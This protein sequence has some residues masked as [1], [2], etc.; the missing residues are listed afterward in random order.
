MAPPRSPG[1]SLEEGEEE[2][3]RKI[4]EEGQGIIEVKLEGETSERTL[5]AA[6][7]DAQ[8]SASPQHFKEDS[9]KKCEGKISL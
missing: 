9:V 7:S 1:S 5:S 2:N 8:P 3:E 4:E 6:L